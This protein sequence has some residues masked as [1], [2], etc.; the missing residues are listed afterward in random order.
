LKDL[1]K[2]IE[3]LESKL[4]ARW[5][6]FM[7][8]LIFPAL[9]LAGGFFFN[10]QLEDAR[11]DMTK[12]IQVAQ[13]SFQQLG[14]EIRRI[15]AAQKFLQELFSGKVE[16]AMLSE[17]LM[18]KLLAD[19]E[20]A[21]EISK[22]VEEYYKAEISEALRENDVEK[23]SQIQ[24]AAGK[25]RSRAA[26]FILKDEYFVIVDSPETRETAINKAKQ[27]EKSGFRAEVI[28]SITGFYGVAIGRF[29]FDEAKRV[30]E[31]AIQK[32]FAKEDSYFM[33]GDRVIENVYPKQ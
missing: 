20:L 27:L 13:Q 23:A 33:T 26:E 1:E 9:L 21:L 24:T 17:K 30:R 25:I 32:G 11:Q 19:D 16:R 15:E 5:L 7:Q 2:R 28:K 18:S 10:S 29:D 3:A 12:E 14:L 31:V 8:Y 4:K 6:F 22:T